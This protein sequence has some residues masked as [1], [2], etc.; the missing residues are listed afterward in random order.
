MTESQPDRRPS[1]N[2]VEPNP[3]MQS[4]VLIMM[5]PA[6]SRSICDLIE[7]L[8][9]NKALTDEQAH[10]YAFAKRLRAHYFEMSKMFAKREAGESFNK[11]PEIQMT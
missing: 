11:R 3:H 2:I 7:G 10:L 4:N 6:M 1:F 5:N 8:A 9:E